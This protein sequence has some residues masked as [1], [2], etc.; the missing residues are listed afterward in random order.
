MTSLIFLKNGFNMFDILDFLGYSLM[1]IVCFG[2][3]SALIIS[4]YLSIQDK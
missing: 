1:I 3:I 4:V 2:F